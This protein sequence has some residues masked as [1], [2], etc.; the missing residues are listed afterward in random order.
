[1]MSREKGHD[2]I[3]EF[4][5]IWKNLG[6]LTLTTVGLY[7]QD[8]CESAG[9]DLRVFETQKDSSRELQ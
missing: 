6:A 3:E 4:R 2:T 7:L 9:G 1:M 8:S 5:V